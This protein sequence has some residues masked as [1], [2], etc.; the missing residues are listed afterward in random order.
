MEKA[1]YRA[2]LDVGDVVVVWSRS[3]GGRLK[4]AGRSERLSGVGRNLEVRW[5]ARARKT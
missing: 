4:K 1:R 3:K 2:V 5:I